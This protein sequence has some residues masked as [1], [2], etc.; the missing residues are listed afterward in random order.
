MRN[1]G[2]AVPGEGS[3]GVRVGDARRLAETLEVLSQEI[4][5]GEP[6]IDVTI[7]SPPYAN[8][9][10]YGIEG[11]IGFGQTE[12]E[13]F[14]DCEKLF[15]TLFA[16][17]R[18]S[19]A[20]WLVVDTYLSETTRNGD[21]PSSL[22]PL[23][24]VLSSLAE[25]HGWTLRE[26]VIWRK[27]K[28][29]PWSHHG[30]FRNAFEYVLLLVKSNSYKFDLDQ[31]RSSQDLARWWVRYPERYNLSGKAPDNVWDIPIPVQGSWGRREYAHACPL[32]PELVR[33]LVLLSSS[34]GDLVFDPFAGVGT[35]PAVAEALGRRALGTEL[36]P[37]FVEHF[38]KHVREEVESLI[39]SAGESLEVGPTPVL[40]EQLRLLKLPKA[41]YVKYRQA[42]LEAISIRSIIVGRR[43][44]G[45]VVGANYYFVT[46][47]I[48]EASREQAQK[49]LAAI[50]HNAPFT[51]YGFSAQ[52]HL[53]SREA[54]AGLVGDEEWNVYEHG[55]TWEVSQ[56]AIGRDALEIPVSSL[57]G[58][59]PP[60]L[61]RDRV[62]VN[63]DFVSDAAAD[64]P[65]GH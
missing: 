37:D 65:R 19:G 8:L 49:I 23:P 59:F 12:A 27:D 20:V 25:R 13:Y 7:T 41:A 3:Y 18:D 15:A 10:D 56:T 38:R 21:S 16:W 43:A 30:K 11:Q 44:G 50:L 6:F 52:I 54:A 5:G 47:E 34:V 24:F 31:L 57:R 33:R 53:V 64:N 42:S 58:K 1:D 46:E 39:S 45:E 51:K 17:T 29:R 61:A 4:S 63:L 22:R 2:P 36:N 28:T 9:V 62:S 32:P 40:L 55:R 48:D 14:D 60:V 26:V 35:V